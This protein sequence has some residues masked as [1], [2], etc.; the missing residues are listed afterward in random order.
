MISYLHLDKLKLQIKKEI[1]SFTISDP[2]VFSDDNIELFL[3][4]VTLPLADPAVRLEG[5]Q[6]RV[7]NALT[8]ILLEEISDIDRAS[9]FPEIGKIEPFLQKILYLVNETEYRN[10][11]SARAGLAKCIDK[12]G[13]NPNN[14]HLS[15]ASYPAVSAMPSFAVHVL[16]AYN[17]RNLESHKCL[18]DIPLQSTPLSWPQSSGFW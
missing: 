7:P 16:R 8:K 4:I 5:L 13:L 11:A 17:L 10:I 12:L 6:T 15:T 14:L 3:R 2:S 1:I 9:F 18:V